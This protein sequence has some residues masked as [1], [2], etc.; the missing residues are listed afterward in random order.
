MST[1]VTAPGLKALFRA[2][3]VNLAVVKKMLKL[4]LNG[5]S[6]LIYLRAPNA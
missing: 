1:I 6:E 2:S 3:R 4:T 5:A